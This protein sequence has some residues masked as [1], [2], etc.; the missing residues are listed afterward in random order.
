MSQLLT[1]SLAGPSVN[2]RLIFICRAHVRR[3]D[4]KAEASYHKMEEYMRHVED[5]FR[6]REKINQAPVKERRVYLATDEPTVLIEARRK[7]VE[8]AVFGYE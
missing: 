8:I 7:Y 1:G 5:W 2:L 3:T 6:C 4:K